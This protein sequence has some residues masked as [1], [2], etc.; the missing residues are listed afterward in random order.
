[1]RCGRRAPGGRAR[2]T[3]TPELDVASAGVGTRFLDAFAGRI[4]PAAASLVVHAAYIE[5]ALR[6]HCAL[7]PL[8]HRAIAPCRHCATPG[9]P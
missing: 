8:R 7:Q 4:G 1:M 6:G 5:A 2:A 3:V 9:R